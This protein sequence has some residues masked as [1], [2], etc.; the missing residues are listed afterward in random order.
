MPAAF[1]MCATGDGAIEHAPAGRQCA[2]VLIAVGSVAVAVLATK[3]WDVYTHPVHRTP[4][5]VADEQYLA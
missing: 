5:C 1:E 4:P 2:G 3:L